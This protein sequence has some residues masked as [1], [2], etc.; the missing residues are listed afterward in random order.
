MK[1]GKFNGLDDWD[2]YI[3]TFR[4]AA[5]Y[6]RWDEEDKHC[7]LINALE[8]EARSVY[9]ENTHTDFE[10]LVFVLGERFQP[11]DQTAAYQNRLEARYYKPGEDASAYSA[12]L[13]RLARKAYPKIPPQSLESVVLA[14]FI[15]NIQHDK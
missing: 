3:Q 13:R 8:K 6:N 9:T 7:Q 14:T 2:D 4:A 10:G 12:D 5:A 11:S 1:V 15:R